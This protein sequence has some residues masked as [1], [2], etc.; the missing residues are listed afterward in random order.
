MPRLS[1]SMEEGTIVRWLVD[2]GGEVARGDE[3]AEIETDKA[4]MT[5]E[6]DAAGRLHRL[7][8]EGETLAV[9][10]PIAE[11]LG[12]GE[13]PSGGDSGAG[14]EG[15]AGGADAQE[16]ASAAAEGDAAEDSG[17]AADGGD[18][19]AAPSGGG[20][21][22]RVPASGGAATAVAE[23]PT[24][25]GQ[26]VK[27]SPLAR[28]IARER[29]VELAGVEGSG[30]NGR[31]VK[32][33]V[34]AAAERGAAAPAAA[35][36]AG[37]PAAAAPSGEA[38]GGAKGAVEVVEPTRIQQV[39][40]RRMSESKATIPDFQVRT[41]ADV[42]E[43]L[44]LRRTLKEH[45]RNASVN[46]FVVKACALAL[47]EHPKANGAFADGKFQ[48]H[49]RVN[50]GVAVAGEGTLVVPTVFDA[51]RKPVTEIAAETR[52][53]AGK[54]RDNAITPPELAG[55]TFTV[56][57]LGMYGITSFTAVVNPGQAAILAV[58]AAVKRAVPAEEGDGFAFRSLMD[59]SLSCDH[60]ILYGAE[61]AEFLARVR[62]LLESPWSL[63]S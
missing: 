39:I 35:N 50:V 32:A 48:L 21:T 58:G 6:A 42:T 16:P 30:P 28:R 34:E 25:A 3:I 37:A 18:G 47:R 12:E 14:A 51:D 9:G 19:A 54:V 44:E 24:K 10:A 36:G 26:R 31:I 27:A 23:A 8:L 45:D 22:E 41:E 17:E 55:G 52:A 62:E 60:R 40:A 63:I 13:E 43:L 53:L 11:L 57:N 20:E 56:S 59:L 38:A 29:G 4:T 49:E 7:A 33:D 5:F 61:A 15:S 46:D 1:D 2:D